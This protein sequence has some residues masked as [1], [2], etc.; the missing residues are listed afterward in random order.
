[1]AE[2]PVRRA[3][4]LR[5][6]MEILR[7]AGTKLL[8]SSRIGSPALCA[9]HCMRLALATIHARP[10]VASWHRSCLVDGRTQTVNRISSPSTLHLCTREGKTGTLRASR[11]QNDAA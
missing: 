5:T 6:T 8:G 3:L 10:G 9:L 4:L 11:R 7:E 1:V 2:E